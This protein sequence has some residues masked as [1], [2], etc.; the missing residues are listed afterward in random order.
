MKKRILSV[1]LT[2]CMVLSL[3]QSFSL[4]AYA[5][6]SVITAK[7]NNNTEVGGNSLSD[8]ISKSGFTSL[9]LS[10][11]TSIEITGGE[12]TDADWKYIKDKKDDLKFLTDFK[13]CSTVTTVADIPSTMN[14][15]IFSS[16]IET[17]N[18][19]KTKNIGLCAFY[20]LAN[21]TNVS[22]PDA[23]NIG[24]RAFANCSSLSTISFP[25]ASKIETNAFSMCDGLVS[26]NFPAVTT[27]GEQ[28]FWQCENLTSA[29]FPAVEQIKQGSFT[30]CQKLSSLKLPKTPP[31]V[32]TAPNHP[33]GD[34]AKTKKL[35]FVDAD[36]KDLTGTALADAED[37]YWAVSKYHLWYYEWI[38]KDL[39]PI[40]SVSIIGTAQV[41]KTLN[42]VIVPEGATVTYVWE[43]GYY[44][45]TN[46]TYTP[47]PL[48]KGKKITLHVTG[49]KWYT[50]YITSAATDEVM[51]VASQ[52]EAVTISGKA[53]VGET[54][55][56]TVAPSGA[57]ASYQWKADGAN[58]GTDSAAYTVLEKDKGKIITITATGI[59]DN[60]SGTVESIIGMPVRDETTYGYRY[61]V[62][63]GN[64]T[65][66]KGTDEGTLKVSY[67]SD[68]G[69]LEDN[70]IDI[71]PLITITGETNKYG[72]AVDDVTAKIKLYNVS[73]DSTNNVRSAF[74]LLNKADVDLTLKGNNVLIGTTAE[75]G[76]HVASGQTITIG[77]TASDSL[78]ATGGWF[79]DDWYGGGAGIGGSRHETAGNIKIT[80]G[81]ITATAGACGNAVPES[82]G[83]AGIGSGSGGGGNSVGT[84]G[85][86]TITG[87]TVIAKGAHAGAGIGGGYNNSGG[88]ITITGGN[89]TAKG[90]VFAAG[91]GGG[92]GIS[93]ETGAGDGGTITISGE[94]ITAIAGDQAAGIGG[95]YYGKGGD[96]TITGGVVIAKTILYAGTGIG[97]GCF[98]EGGNIT[99]TGGTVTAGSNCGSGIGGG[100]K[101]NNSTYTGKIKIDAPA[102]VTAFSGYYK[103]FKAINGDG[104]NG[105]L[106]AGSTA[107]I[108]QA[109]YENGKREG[110][111][112][113][114]YIKGSNEKIS[115]ICPSGNYYSVAFT[116]SD[117]NTYELKSAG[118]LQQYVK[119]DNSTSTDFI[120]AANG[121]TNFNGVTDSS[122]EKAALTAV[123]VNGTAKVGQTLTTTL[124]PN[125][126]AATY[127][128]KAGNA[129]IADATGSTYTPTATDIGKTITVIATGAGNYYGAV[130]SDVTSAVIEAEVS[131]YTVTFDSQSADTVAN[132][133]SK[134]VIAPATN[135]SALPTGPV[136]AGY[137][138][139]G[140]YTQ[141]NGGGTQFTAT[142]TVTAD[143]TVY[144]QWNQ[145]TYSITGKVIEDGPINNPIVVVTGAAITLKAG[146]RQVAPQEAQTIITD[147]NGEFTISNVPNGTYNL[148][149][150]KDDRTITLIITVLNKDTED[151]LAT[152]PT[153]KRNSVLEVKDNTPEIIVDGLNDFFSNDPQYSED[154][155]DVI[156]NGGKVEIKLTVE[157]KDESGSNAAEKADEI[158]ATAGSE[159]TIGLFL[160]L[161]MSKTV[162]SLSSG[163][164]VTSSAITLLDNVLTLDI[165]LPAEL[166]G[167]S[168]YVIYRYHD[169]VVNTITQTN[170][171]GEYFE[172]SSDGKSI[173]LYTK[174]FSTYAIAY[175]VASTPNTGGG[176]SGGGG[177]SV[178]SVSTSYT[179]TASAGEGGSISP[180][181][182]VSVANGSGK[183]FTITAD[184]GYNI[185]DVLV[186]GVSVGA[187]TSYIFSNVSS[188]HTIGA[189]F[190]LKKTVSTD[191]L[192][193]YMQ[194]GKKVFIGFT[195]VVDNILKYTAPKGMTVQFVKNLKNFTDIENHWAKANIDFVTEREIF[196]GTGN[197]KYS[198][199]IGMTRGMFVTVIGKLYERSYGSIAGNDT[200]SDVNTN[201]YYA[202]YVAWANEN[203]IIKGIG[204]NQFAPNTE[205]TREQMATIMFQFATF[206]GKAP[207]GNWMINVTYP[208]KADISDWAMNSTDK[209]Y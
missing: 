63:K 11:I 200:F 47:I 100:Y 27:I 3:M 42:A 153:G 188:A 58:V 89:V 24:E 68:K 197:N 77:G 69:Q 46:A 82:K 9:L 29:I 157:K 71:D 6:G 25:K 12:V 1:L 155:K 104:T 76:I 185:S 102:K 17:V 128:W 165:P 88:N 168:G 81:N 176:G 186:D 95:G 14:I 75:A 145:N 5:E 170:N 110:T 106:E 164:T 20:N 119:T 138:F 22:F 161:T 137:T 94:N 15:P 35:G 98:A 177:G 55:S 196:A 169:G 124:T 91:I 201:A 79:S 114:L 16:S 39:I 99:I 120:I 150:S 28:A 116:V 108:L 207:Q 179:I 156:S 163:T 125:G 194:D 198:P 44:G 19:A 132:P 208:D 4:P 171:D 84:T 136:K 7:I 148:F 154:D 61:D 135:V 33:F 123:K 74:E 37:T 92:N 129:D 53:Q 8:V 18:I 113:T 73:I 152:L 103:G 50:G 199:N 187:V 67:S 189:V 191:G 206:L 122:A 60:Y 54:L 117:N 101:D 144:A 96:I 90:G 159:K 182:K 126:A 180:N 70:Y 13:V 78:N 203:G 183:T 202:K 204:N 49:T 162:T 45:G 140:W 23:T 184:E 31:E 83:G 57:K 192:P 43:G 130:T 72:V 151:V 167:K 174:K 131:T 195:A 118:L 38:I 142:T 48:D 105:E 30:H 26:V 209:H 10:T 66:S 175:T 172:L 36:G 127:K 139:G 86:I 64:I 41:G 146:P 121:I 143:I 112:S 173:K 52:L 190:E 133:T 134:P 160:D 166:Q 149:V 147:V 181:G 32:I 56:A 109:N 34:C 107:K 65:I 115:E 62:S 193:Y 51:D 59:T 87:G 111:D 80:G 141:P 40:E 158:K 205:V 2:V 21:L 85:N 178:G 93:R 97:G